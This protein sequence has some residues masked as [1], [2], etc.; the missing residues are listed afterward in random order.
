[1]TI[2][3]AFESVDLIHCY[4]VLEHLSD[5]IFFL[6]QCERVLKIG[7]IINIVVPHYQSELAY[8]DITHQRFFTLDTFKTAFKTKEY[9]TSYG[10]GDWR[11]N[12]IGSIAIGIADRNLC[13]ITQLEKI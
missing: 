13:I 6:K 3:Y 2:P 10:Y 9:D 4:H 11:L 8:H 1:M 5:P 12:E 7:G